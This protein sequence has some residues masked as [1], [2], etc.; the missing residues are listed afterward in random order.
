MERGRNGMGWE[1]M[2][3]WIKGWMNGWMDKKDGW[4]RID[5]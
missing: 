4:D 2:D 5:R 1:G 3:G